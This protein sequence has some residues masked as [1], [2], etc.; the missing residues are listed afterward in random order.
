[1]QYQH[2]YTCQVAAAS[3]PLT[4][5]TVRLITSFDRGAA[6]SEPAAGVNVCLVAADGRCLL[7]RV[8]PVNDPQEAA[9]SM[10]EICAVRAEEGLWGDKRGG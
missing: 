4:V 5:Y 7:H 2:T 3:G 6:L 9:S 10:D 8:P 1:M